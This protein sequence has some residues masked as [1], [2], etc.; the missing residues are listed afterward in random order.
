LEL[1][2]S[3]GQTVTESFS[4]PV[5]LGQSVLGQVESIINQITDILEK[6]TNVDIQDTDRKTALHLAAKE[7]GNEEVVQLLVEHGA[8]V[9]TL[10]NDARAALSQEAAAATLEWAIKNGH[11]KMVHLLLVQSVDGVKGESGYGQRALRWAMGKLGGF[12]CTED[13]LKQLLQDGVNVRNVDGQRALLWALKFH[14]GKS[15]ENKL[16]AEVG[17]S[18]QYE[19]KT[20]MYVAAEDGLEEIATRLAEL[21]ADT[22]TRCMDQTALSV[23][24]KNGHWGVV[25]KL[26]EKGADINVQVGGQMLYPCLLEKLHILEEEDCDCW[27]DEHSGLGPCEH[28]QSSQSLPDILKLLVERMGTDTGINEVDESGSTAPHIA[29]DLCF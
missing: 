22:N 10:D 29:S 14:K 11:T 13:T 21:G 8:D 3:L 7:M 26:V 28:E 25:R 1:T 19:G 4:N 2:R 17:I 16:V 20:A 27:M 24:A 6:L 23:A 18:A 9:N 5:L 15:L 12:P